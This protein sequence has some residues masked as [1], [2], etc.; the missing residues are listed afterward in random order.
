MK[1]NLLV[2]CL[3]VLSAGCAFPGKELTSRSELV[4][5]SAEHPYNRDNWYYCGTDAENHHFITRIGGNTGTFIVPKEQIKLA[6]TVQLPPSGVI[7]IRQVY[8]DRGF[9]FGQD[10]RQWTY[11]H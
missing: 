6:R 3:A 9:E 4:R 10:T 8:P 11:S 2:S 5:F 1:W 7:T